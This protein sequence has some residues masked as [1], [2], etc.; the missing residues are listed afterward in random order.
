MISLQMLKL[1]TT[2]M[3]IWIVCLYFY[4]TEILGQKKW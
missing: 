3:V 1:L 4:V 2:T